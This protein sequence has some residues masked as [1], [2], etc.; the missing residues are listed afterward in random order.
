VVCV[1]T[2]VAYLD[3]ALRHEHLGLPGLAAV[4]ARSH[5]VVALAECGAFA[6]AR[7]PAEEGVQIAEASKHPY[8]RVMAW[9]AVGFRALCQGDLPQAILVLEQ[10]LTLVQETD[11][12]L[13]IP[14][15]TAPLGAAYARADRSADAV[16]LLE[17]AVAQ[18]VARQYLW[19]QALRMV[20]LGEAY[21]GTSRLAEAEAQAQQALA[22][23]H[24]HQE[25]GHEAYALWLCGAVAAQWATP[26]AA[27]AGTYYRQALTLADGLGMRPL[28][29]HCHQGL[30]TL[31]AKRG[32]WEQAR[33][34]L[35]AAID[36][37]RALEMTFWLPQAEA[38]LAQVEAR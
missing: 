20:W 25:R 14:M 17:E 28:Q 32:E 31:Y 23:A 13:L 33:A 35:A 12:R 18:A 8:S 22:F 6:E 15:V 37:Y 19:D 3:G 29:A 1:Q 24:A 16:P 10:A 38:V 34:A 11:L 7:A 2:N 4:F 21:L 5:L 30:G 27:Q 36:L 26:E 9:W